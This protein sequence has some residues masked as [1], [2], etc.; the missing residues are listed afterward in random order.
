[1][2]DTSC[3]LGGKHVQKPVDFGQQFCFQKGTEFLPYAFVQEIDIFLKKCP[4]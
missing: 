3:N 1:M 2:Y 4:I